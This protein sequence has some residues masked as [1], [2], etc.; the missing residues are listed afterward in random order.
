M[1]PINCCR[2]PKTVASALLEN[3]GSRS[4]ANSFEGVTD[5]T[6]I[7]HELHLSPLMTKMACAVLV[8]RPTSM[9][10]QVP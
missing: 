2:Y 10:Y 3:S 7:R 4:K 5:I 8:S 6:V 9:Q 1:F